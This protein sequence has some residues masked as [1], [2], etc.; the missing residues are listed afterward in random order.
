MMMLA[1]CGPEGL[2]CTP[3]GDKPGFVRI[4]DRNTLV[5]PD[6]RGNNRADSLR[7]IIRDN[8]VAMLFLIPGI[9]TTLRVNGTAIVSIDDALIQSF[10]M[11]GKLPRT[12][13]VM[14]VETAFFHCARSFVRSRLW[15][16]ESH[17]DP[18]SVP[19]P[20]QIL[21][22]LSSGRQGGKEYDDE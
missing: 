14:K 15:D 19:S 18:K 9:G 10:S 20:G 5:F 3:R 6:R 16:P 13:V 2:D 21:A 1:T 4:V 11:D 17:V 12:V 22:A 7:N 8:R